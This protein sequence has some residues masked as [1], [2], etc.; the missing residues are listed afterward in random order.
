M[1]KIKNCVVISALILSLFFILPAICNAQIVLDKAFAENAIIN[2]ANQTTK[3][4]EK[5][6][7]DPKEKIDVKSESKVTS[8]QTQKET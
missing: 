1:V 2:S 7:Q 8:S 3:S 4:E 6:A 5:K